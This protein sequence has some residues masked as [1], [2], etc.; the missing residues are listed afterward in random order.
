M[1]KDSYTDLTWEDLE[2]WA[3][4]T[5]VSRGRTYQRN[6]SVSDLG[7]TPE[8][9]LIAYV[10]GSTR[11][12][13]QVAIH[14]GD[15][16]SACTC[17][18]WASCK[19]AVAVVLEYLTCLK[20]NVEVPQIPQ[21]DSRLDM[22][23]E[24]ETTAGEEYWDPELGM[25]T[26]VKEQPKAEQQQN[27]EPLLA[28]LE[29]QTKAQLVEL[30]DELTDAFP[31]VR[32]FLEDRQKVCSGNADT[33]HKAIRNEIT[34]IREPYWNDYNYRGYQTANFDRLHAY[35]QALLQEGQADEIVYLG[36][37]LIA[38]VTFA[39]ETYDRE[40]EMIDKVK[41]SI[42]TVI[43]A[44]ALSSLPSSEQLAWVVDTAL[45]DD[46][47]LCTD[48]L[49]TFWNNREKKSD[50][51]ELADELQKRLNNMPM[52]K[53]AD[54]DIST[55]RRDQLSNWLIS[56]LECAG[57][58][59]EI[60]PL[61]EQEAEITGD[62]ERLIDRL[63][64]ENRFEDAENWCHRAIANTDPNHP[65]TLSALKD[66]LRI[67]REKTGDLLGAA[68]FRTD[69]FFR[70][71][72]MLTFRELCKSAQKAKV[73]PAV[74][75]WA[76]YFLETGHLPRTKGRKRKGEPD[77][78]WPLPSTGFHEDIRPAEGPVTHTLIEIAI[79]EKQI[80]EV[81]KWY[82]LETSRPEYR[83]GY[84]PT[85]SLQIAEMVKEKYPDRT[86]EIWK[87]MAE[88]E[89]SR[90]EVSGYREASTY[91]REVRDTLK[92]LNKEDE[93]EAY[94]SELR[95]QNK[96]RPRCLEVLDGLTGKRIIDRE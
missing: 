55:Y 11:Y 96:R 27:T 76:R 82:D 42:E 63:I 78:K 22:L 8:G 71:P 77:D 81:L 90:V 40:G 9:A 75:A 34:D 51:S 49:K 43:Q 46:Y 32:E 95:D 28:Y 3:G 91:L 62:Y 6:S 33:L 94:L 50:W 65:G 47:Y 10:L 37:E 85:S 1:E 18:Y 84:M 12:V 52:S 23:Q 48:A 86:I 39:I 58:E 67:I 4:T 19:H 31:D 54:G 20:N 15:L 14:D 38:A 5:I 16:T 25:W 59:N 30:L 7:I 87:E 53:D 24:T 56:V 13:T 70:R 69:N 73:R 92:H 79:A 88:S 93:W 83:R 35:L 89:I 29:K 74:E 68:A 26:D 44:L 45:A 41:P 64:A 2:D 80:E 21:T 61:C 66:R 17:P 72:S 60:L 57:R 36:K